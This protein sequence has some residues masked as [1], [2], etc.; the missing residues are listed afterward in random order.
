MKFPSAARSAATVSS[1]SCTDQIFHRV[2]IAIGDAVC[3]LVGPPI[4]RSGGPIGEK[5]ELIFYPII[6]VK[7]EY[8]V[9]LPQHSNPFN[10]HLD[11]RLKFNSMKR[12][13]PLFALLLLLFASCKRE[14]TQA[15]LF[16]ENKSGVVLI[17]NKY[18]YKIK[19]P[20]GQSMFFSDLDKD[21]DLENVTLDV[22]EIRNNCSWM[23]GTGF[24]VDN[25][26]TIMTNRHVAQPSI[27]E[28]NIKAGYRNLIRAVQ[29]YYE[30]QKQQLSDRFDELEK[31]KEQYAYN[32]EYD[33]VEEGYYSNDARINEIEQEQSKLKSQYDQCDQAIQQLNELDDPRA[34]RISS[35]CELG[36]AYNNTHVTGVEDFL[37]KNPCVVIKTSDLEDVDLALI[38]LKNKRTPGDAK[39]FTI[40]DEDLP[41]EMGQPLYMIGYNAGPDLAKTSTGIQAQ[42]TSGKVTQLPDGQRVLYDIATVQGSSGSPVIDAEGNLVAVNFAKLRVSDN[43]NFGIPLKRVKE[44]MKR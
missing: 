30:Y 36:I 16:D 7:I 25:N 33:D 31:N 9:S 5:I 2:P 26:G 44:F 3:R 14:L 43:F 19:L 41:L 37:G 35:V 8:F 23:S 27:D 24:F 39:V 32:E 20:N 10:E 42:M 29:Q 38:Q 18:Y 11:T 13:L 21:G 22:N 28:N 12:L 40:E 17:L 15:E 6:E 4:V 1:R 34:L